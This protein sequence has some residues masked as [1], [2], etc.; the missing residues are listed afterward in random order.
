M[1]CERA[2]D[3]ILE[4]LLEPQSGDVQAMIDAHVAGCRSCA[5]FMEAQHDLDRQLSTHLRPP[6]LQ[7]GFRSAVRRRVRQE[8]RAFWPDL[9]PDVLHF[10]S[11]GVV[12]LLALIWLPF[13]V[14]VV[15]AT[16]GVFTLLTHVLLTA[17]HE[18]LDAAEDLAS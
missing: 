15:L 9:L 8:S 7:P 12:T 1:E 17:F 6:A 11:W 4:S 18:S 2:Q 5:A 10:A 13:S 16:A 14:P 3:A